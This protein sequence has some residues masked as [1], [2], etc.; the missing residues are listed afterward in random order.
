MGLVQ[1]TIRLSM[2]TIIPILFK[3][4]HKMES[5]GTLPNSFYEAT[6]TLSILPWRW[7]GFCPI[8]NFLQF[9]FIEDFIRDF[10]LLLSCLMFQIDFKNW[11]SAYYFL[12]SDDIMYI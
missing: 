8:R 12:T 3:L 10:L 5:E 7:N 6:V 11:L 1:N 9:P 2:K 4:V